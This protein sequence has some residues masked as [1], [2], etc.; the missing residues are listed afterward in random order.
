MI[1]EP[2]YWNIPESFN[3]YLDNIK[4]NDEDVVYFDGYWEDVRYLL[5]KNRLFKIFKFRNTDIN[6]SAIAKEMLSGESVAVHIRRGDYVK[7]SAQIELPKN[8][9]DV[10]RPEYY[11]EA[12]QLIEKKLDHLHYYVFSDDLEYAKGLIGEGRTVT[13][14]KG[15]KDYDDLQLMTLCK[16]HIIANSTF[17]FWGAYL[18][19][20]DGINIAPR[21]HSI[22]MEKD[23]NTVRDF[24]A[25]DGW[26]YVENYK[27]KGN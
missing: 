7:E 21:V 1:V 20:Y 4:F 19:K 16:H 25:V 18:S 22:R 24:F 12:I 14:V 27:K 17:S 13:L 15:N 6:T 26:Q 10:C 11:E 5:D 2:V 23:G 8:F 3:E 9:Y